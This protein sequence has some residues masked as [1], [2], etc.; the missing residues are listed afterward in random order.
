MD[1]PIGAI[2]G[3][4]AGNIPFVP[5]S[6]GLPGAAVV[7][8][9][10]TCSEL[11][12]VPIELLPWTRSSSVVCRV[13]VVCHNNVHNRSHPPFPWLNSS[14]NRPTG[15]QCEII[16]RSCPSPVRNI[17]KLPDLG[18]LSL[19]LGFVPKRQQRR[20]VLKTSKR[21]LSWSMSNVSYRSDRSA[22]LW[23]R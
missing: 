2:W 10:V 3:V 20:S 5:Q 22:T 19:S 17:F 9:R 15:F 6:L 8:P 12:G 7:R 16:L 21:Q 4:G 13:V 1:V 11:L 18:D 14:R 23:R